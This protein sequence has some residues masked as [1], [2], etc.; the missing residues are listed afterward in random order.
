ME[1]SEFCF[2]W[3]TGFLVLQ[4]GLELDVF[5]NDLKLLISLLP[6]CQC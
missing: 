2:V 5:T 6:P 3:N 4:A 1:K